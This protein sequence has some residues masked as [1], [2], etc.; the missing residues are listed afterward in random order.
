MDGGRLG[1]CVLDDG[2]SRRSAAGVADGAPLGI[3]DVV[4]EP[5]STP[6][7]MSKEYAMFMSCAAGGIH[8]HVHVMS[9]AL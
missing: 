8:V 3:T 9:C 4:S 5:E 6:T 7:V 2:M 1:R